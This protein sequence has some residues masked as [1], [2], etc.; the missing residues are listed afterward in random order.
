[1][2]DALLSCPFF[3]SLH[4]LGPGR[5]RMHHPCSVTTRP[6]WMTEG[7]NARWTRN[8]GQ[9]GGDI[10][11]QLGP[12]TAPTDFASLP[13]VK[14]KNTR[15]LGKHNDLPWSTINDLFD[16]FPLFLL[17]FPTIDTSIPFSSS[18][19]GFPGNVTPSNIHS[20]FR[21]VSA[22]QGDGCH[23]TQRCRRGGGSQCVAETL[24]DFGR[25]G[26]GWD[27]HDI[28]APTSL[29][30]SK[31][32]TPKSTP[33]WVHATLVNHETKWNIMKSWNQ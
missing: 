32:A 7:G 17:I 8:S 25:C 2:R 5:L 1:M 6:W 16:S 24:Y 21:D 18:R 30:L 11:T 19:K 14:K 4:D 15:M 27:H 10:R 31:M 26:D 28:K 3:V 29:G 13:T 22:G 23:Q 20:C 12:A 9:W 33:K